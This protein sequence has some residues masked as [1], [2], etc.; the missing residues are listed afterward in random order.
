MPGVVRWLMVMVTVVPDSVAP[1]CGGGRQVGGDSPSARPRRA[2]VVDHVEAVERVARGGLQRARGAGGGDVLDVG[3]A[4]DAVRHPAESALLPLGWDA[5]D[6]DGDLGGLATTVVAGIV[7]P[8]LRSNHMPACLPAASRAAA[9]VAS[10]G[11]ISVPAGV[12]PPVVLV[13]GSSPCSR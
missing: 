9:V 8:V 4:E 11:K 12:A 6:Q 13:N 2:D 1:C 7:T 5:G 10:D 3:R